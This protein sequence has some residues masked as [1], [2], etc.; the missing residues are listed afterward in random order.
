LLYNV[1]LSNNL[2]ISTSSYYY[3]ITHPIKEITELIKYKGLRIKIERI[4]KKHPLLW[5][6]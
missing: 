5:L 1:S 3:A 4:I 6:S 2:N